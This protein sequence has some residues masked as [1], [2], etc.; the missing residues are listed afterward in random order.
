MS[1]LFIFYTYDENK[2]KLENRPV[3]SVLIFVV[4]AL[5]DMKYVGKD[6]GMYKQR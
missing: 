5:V 2:L 6:L 4:R 1:I 3:L